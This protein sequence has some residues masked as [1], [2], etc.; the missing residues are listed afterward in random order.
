MWA[1]VNGHLPIVEFLISKGANIDATDS[2]E[3]T[4]LMRAYMEKHPSIVEFLISKGANIEATDSYGYT[5]LMWVLY[6]E[7]SVNR[8]VSDKQRR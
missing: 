1:S 6:G 3:H 8:R 7:T 2:Y 5:P 4:P